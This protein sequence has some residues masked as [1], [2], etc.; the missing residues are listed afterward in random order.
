MYLEDY[1]SRNFDGKSVCVVGN[2]EIHTKSGTEIDSH[3]IVIRINHF[4]LGNKYKDF[5]GEKVTHWCVHCGN[6]MR[7]RY[8]FTEALC[9]FPGRFNN[10]DYNVITPDKDWRKESGVPRM[11]TGG[12]LLYIMGSLSV[13]ADI[14]GFDFLKTG[15]YF[16]NKHTHKKVHLENIDKEEKLIRELHTIYE[17]HQ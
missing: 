8:N 3:D 11:T 16:N 5:I 13:V 14:Y 9:P 17:T 15:H 12:T 7:N 10:K 6:G 1:I 2:A 4:R